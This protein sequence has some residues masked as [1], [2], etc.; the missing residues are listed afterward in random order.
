VRARGQSMDVRIRLVSLAPTELCSHTSDDQAA[1][2]PPT[3]LTLT[4]V[5]PA[6]SWQLPQGSLLEGG[7]WP[8]WTSCPGQ[9]PCG[10]A[11][12]CKVVG[13][14]NSCSNTLNGPHLS[15]SGGVRT[16]DTT[17]LGHT[18]SRQRVASLGFYP[19][20]SSSLC[21]CLLGFLLLNPLPARSM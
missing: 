3:L 16:S 19:C 8:P 21:S 7:Q 5:P 6:C 13:R 17:L 9:L 1:V 11:S 14:A 18:T 12:P 10:C 15:S 4:C 2:R 20:G